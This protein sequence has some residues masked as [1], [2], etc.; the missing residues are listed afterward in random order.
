MAE[1][2]PFM[3]GLSPI[4]GKPVQLA[5][6]GGRLRSSGGLGL[7][8]DSLDVWTVLVLPTA[9]GMVSPK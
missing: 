1:N 3:P 4:M 9:F 6:D 2:A 7:P 5:F 8:T